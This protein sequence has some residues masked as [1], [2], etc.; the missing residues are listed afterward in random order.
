M[1][2]NSGI[3]FYREKLRRRFCW[4][5]KTTDIFQSMK[6]AFFAVKEPKSCERRRP[7]GER[8]ILRAAVSFAP[9]VQKRSMVKNGKEDVPY[10]NDVLR[11]LPGI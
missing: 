10:F 8:I 7:T 6:I 1:R 5:E 9:N 11:R 4:K 2:T 3:I